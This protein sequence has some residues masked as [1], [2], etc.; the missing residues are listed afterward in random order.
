M[1]PASV[2]ADGEGGIGVVGGVAVWAERAVVGEGSRESQ[3][4]SAATR[5]EQTATTYL[6]RAIHAVCD[7]QAPARGDAPCFL[8][9]QPEDLRLGPPRLVAW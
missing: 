2:R 8:A 3:L 7:E 6:L 5:S 1:V 9:K 4:P